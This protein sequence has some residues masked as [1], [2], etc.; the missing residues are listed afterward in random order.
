MRFLLGCLCAA[1]II[2]T[3]ALAADESQQSPP[4]D[5]SLPT[6]QFY[7]IL[8]ANWSSAT[9]TFVYR[10]CD[11]NGASVRISTSV[12]SGQPVTLAKGQCVD[13]ATQGSLRLTRADATSNNTATG[14]YQ[15]IHALR[16]ERSS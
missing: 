4:S 13:I 10:V 14:T 5:W 12:I 11:T 3:P 16:E 7:T 9:T 15:F 8:L 6:D 2:G 1:A